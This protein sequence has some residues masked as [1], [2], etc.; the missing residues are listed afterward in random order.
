MET[1]EIRE[2]PTFTPYCTA[3][4]TAIGEALSSRRDA[5]VAGTRHELEEHPDQEDEDA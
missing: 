3:C 2:D 4:K 1:V 5:E